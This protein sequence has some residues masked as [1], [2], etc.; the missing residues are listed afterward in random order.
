MHYVYSGE[1]SV[2][3]NRKI[4][5]ARHI[6]RSQNVRPTIGVL[7]ES[8]DR[9][10]GRL[11]W[12]GITDAVRERDVNLIYFTGRALRSPYD[13]KSQANVLYDLVDMEQIDGLIINSSTLDWY[14]TPEEMEDFI[15]GYHPLPIVSLEK[16]FRGLPSLLAGDYQCMREAIVHLI[17]V[18]GYR[19]IAFI[20]GPDETHTGARERY[21]AYTETLAEYGLSVEPNLVTDPL[22]WFSGKQALEQLLAERKLQPGLDFEA[23]A[24]ANDEMALSVMEALQVRGVRVPYEVAVVGFDDLDTSRT[25]TPPLT[26]VRSLFYERGRRAVEL[27]LAQLAGEEV[28]EETTVP[29]RLIVRQ[30]CGCLDPAVM[31][32]TAGRVTAIAGQPSKG[33]I[34]SASQEQLTP[35]RFEARLTARR[36]RII[37]EMVQAVEAMPVG[38]EDVLDPGWAE[39]LFRTFMVGLKEA[40]P[41]IFLQALD[42]IL[43]R[44]IAMGNDVTVWQNVISALRRNV[45]PDLDQAE[46]LLWVEDLWGQARVMIGEAS[47]RAQGYQRVKTEQQAQRLRDLDQRLNI[48]L[49]VD[50]LMDMLTQELP[51]LGIERGYVSLYEDPE[52]PTEKSRL[53]L[54]YDEQGRV[55]LEPGERLFPSRQ[56]APGRMFHREQ[57]YSLMVEALY[58]R[59]EQLGFV[60]FEAGPREAVISEVL[61][62]QISS[63]LRGVLL[64]QERKQAEE[65]LLKERNVLRTLID[66]LPDFIYVKDIESQFII[67]N[68]ALAQAVGAEVPDELVGKTDFDFFPEELAAQYRADE[69]ALINSGQPLL[70]HEEPVIDSRGNQIWISTT[71]V[72]LRDSQGK[73]VGFVGIG[74]NITKRRKAAEVLAKL[75]TELEIVAQVSTAAST[76]LDTADL[77]QG[78]VDLTKDSFGLYHA[79]IYLLN[80]SKERLVLAAGAGA[81]G[82][83]MVAEGWSILLEQEQSL[84]AR[85]ARTRQGVIVNNVRQEPGW[86]PNPL[87]PDTCSELAVPLMVGDR[88]LGVLD[89]QAD[90]V[91]YFT[92]DDIR[93]Q[94][95]L[96]A[97]VAVALENA[98][99]FERAEQEIVER[100]RAEVALAQQAQILDAELERFFYVASHHL[101][102]PLRM[103]TSYSQLLVKRYGDKLGS[104]ADEFIAYVVDGA[105]RIRNLLNDVLTYSLVATHGRPFEPADCNALLKRVLAGLEVTIEESGAVVSHDDLPTVMADGKQLGRLFS[106]LL[107]NAIKFRSKEPPRIHIG[108]EYRDGRSQEETAYW[109][110]SV[111]DN[112]IGIETHYYERIFTIFQQLHAWG[113]YSGTGIGLAIC[114]KIV[115]RHGGRIWVESE[116]GKGATFYFTIPDR[117]GSAS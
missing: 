107:D 19:R 91:N 12:L 27:V 97:Q 81:V 41:D 8:H 105:A 102:E 45:L 78:V 72:P 89:V 33:E 40:K 43:R 11:T 14:I 95:T 42:N 13:F 113:E 99:L 74:R 31:Q 86:L 117:G 37:S 36:D 82:Q 32:V 54:A 9:S 38:P 26:T 57:R 85:A 73:I 20:R 106:S 114:K 66:N 109:M 65:V 1:S 17:E 77:L 101:Q 22:D 76:I 115:E 88:V 15:K 83:Q 110:F 30:S 47:Q 52:K 87:L 69:M 64:I 6:A 63:A 55:K 7:D 34:Q 112:G 59:E 70:D 100:K 51:R 25:V 56:L 48:A 96:A 46:T 67:S 71:K 10:N 39:Q 116:V 16:S 84:V 21:R 111:C 50:E 4:N 79:H 58:F 60:L 61:R 49:D 98:R 18:H 3:K 104:E 23:V 92:N 75:V 62:R 24:A 35:E 108:V 94:A 68:T 2:R 80:E 5:Q 28:P 53:I 103:V 44:V 90:E 93:I 29:G